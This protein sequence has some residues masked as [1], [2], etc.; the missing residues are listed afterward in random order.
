MSITRVLQEREREAHPFIEKHSESFGIDPNLVRGLITQESAFV[1]EAVSATNAYGYGQFTGIGAR[2]VQEVANMIDCPDPEGL[3]TFTKQDAD[4][5]DLGI[6]GVCA[7]LWWLFEKKYKT[8]T[9]RKVQL[10]TALTF[11]NSGGRPAALVVRYG[12][13]A[14]AVPALQ[15]L[16]RNIRSNS[17]TYAPQV[18]AW[19]VKWYEFMKAQEVV[20]PSVPD[21][22]V[23][24]FDEQVA[25]IDKKYRAL[26]EA[27]KLLDNEDDRVDCLI[28]SRDGFTEVTLIFP[29][30]V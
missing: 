30:E 4:D 3:Y 5:P 2:Q 16:P 15:Q 26:V 22:G 27:L 9:D 24:P 21:P 7:F 13:H 6:K 17:V 12:G 29:G 19:Y 10:E 25:G 18:A 28:N 14:Q 11:Y 23:N 20:V 1:A 8:V